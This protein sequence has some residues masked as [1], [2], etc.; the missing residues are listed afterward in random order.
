MSQIYKILLEILKVNYLEDSK[1][2]IEPQFHFRPWL[3]LFSGE[4]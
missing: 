4:S 2:E 1:K 3:L